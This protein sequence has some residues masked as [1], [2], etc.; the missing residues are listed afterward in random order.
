MGLASVITDLAPVYKRPSVESER[1][2]EVLYGMS[3]QVLQTSETGWCYLRTE[4]AMEG[5][6]PLACL[7]QDNAVATAWRKYPKTTVLAPYIDIQK[8]PTEYAARLVSMTRGG[9]LVQLNVQDDGFAKVGLPNGGVGYTRASY[10]GDAIENWRSLSAA[11]MRWNLVETALSYNGVGYRKGG[12]SPLGMDAA[13]LCAM[14]YALNGV[15]IAREVYFKP[16]GEVHPVPPGRMDEGDLLYFH[17]TAGIYIG[18]GKFVH[19]TQD[20]GNEGV[21]I[22]SLRAKDENYNGVLAAQLM[23]VASLYGGQP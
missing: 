12:R 20:K 5:Y 14:S 15:S 3:V 7:E 22:S 13:G 11:D 16:G 23:A 10:L 19:A 2:D 9:V 8:E 6:T 17:N 4:Y 18:E 1:L 21:I